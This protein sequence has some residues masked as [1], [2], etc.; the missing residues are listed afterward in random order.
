MKILTFLTIAISSVPVGIILFALFII[1]IIIGLALAIPAIGY[2]F[3]MGKDVMDLVDAY[4]QVPDTIKD[5]IKKS[6]TEI[7]VMKPPKFP[8]KERL[9]P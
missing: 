6:Q 7:E 4:M 1:Y 5:S 3:I 9:K 2:S 8:Q